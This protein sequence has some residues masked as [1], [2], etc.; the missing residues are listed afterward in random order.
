M[1]L[2]EIL[3]VSKDATQDE[4]KKAARIMRQTYH[5]DKPEGEEKRFKKI[6][7][8]YETLSDPEM[9]ARYDSTGSTAKEKSF[10][11]MAE[12]TLSQLFD[13]ILGTG[14]SNV[15]YRTEQMI[16]QRLTALKDSLRAIKRT[17]KQLLKAKRINKCKANTDLLAGVIYKQRLTNFQKYKEIKASIK[18]LNY[19]EQIMNDYESVPDIFATE[20]PSSLFESPEAWAHFVLNT[21]GGQND[22]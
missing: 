14:E 8:A 21:T 9:R 17:R 10:K 4:I 6:Q 19:L 5:P 13:H 3:G 11:Q 2:Y 7:E 1:T 22:R 20:R 16:A 12:E 18:M 15:V